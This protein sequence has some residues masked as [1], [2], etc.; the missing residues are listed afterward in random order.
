MSVTAGGEIGRRT[1]LRI[2]LLEG[3][4]R[5]QVPPRRYIEAQYGFPEF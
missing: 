5:V 4:M 1:R 3:G 2:W